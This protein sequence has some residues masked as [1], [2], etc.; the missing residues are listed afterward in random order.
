[1]KT[2]SVSEGTACFVSPQAHRDSAHEKEMA[3]KNTKRHEKKGFL[4]L[5][6]LVMPITIGQNS[7]KEIP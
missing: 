4:W 1:L 3:T 2:R 5:C 7:K 6:D